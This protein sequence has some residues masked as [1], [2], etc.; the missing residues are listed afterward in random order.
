M[1][2]AR[3]WTRRKPR[4]TTA[5]SKSKLYPIRC[6]DHLLTLG[7]H[8]ILDKRAKTPSPKKTPEEVEAEESARLLGVSPALRSYLR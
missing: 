4:V 8:S 7:S 3:W 6:A 1:T 2:K 5:D